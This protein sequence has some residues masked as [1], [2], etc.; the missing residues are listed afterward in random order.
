MQRK[1]RFYF[2]I[3]ASVSA[4]ISFLLLRNMIE[5][6]GKELMIDEE[7]RNWGIEEL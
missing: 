7:S 3:T 6:S 4:G 5:L 2:K 1:S